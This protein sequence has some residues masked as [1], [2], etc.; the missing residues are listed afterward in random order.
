M[1]PFLYQLTYIIKFHAFLIKPFCKQSVSSG[2]LLLHIKN[3][4]WSICGFNQVDWE[5]LKKKAFMH[6]YIYLYYHSNTLA[7]TFSC[8]HVIKNTKVLTTH[9]HIYISTEHCTTDAT[10]TYKLKHFYKKTHSHSK[11]FSP[12]RY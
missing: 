1:L 7:T 5:S 6:V 3:M 2:I 9:L 8:S 10:V 4:F 12:G 11:P